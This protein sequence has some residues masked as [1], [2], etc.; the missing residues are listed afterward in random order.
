MKRNH[1]ESGKENNNVKRQK[2]IHSSYYGKILDGKR[3]GIQKIIV[4]G[5]CEPL[6]MICPFVKGIEHGECYTFSLITA[7]IASCKF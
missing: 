7:F 4:S 5:S 6:G 1:S 2:V 3:D